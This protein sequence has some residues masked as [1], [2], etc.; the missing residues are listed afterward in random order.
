MTHALHSVCLYTYESVKY[1][2]FIHSLTYQ[3]LRTALILESHKLYQEKYSS[4]FRASSNP[5]TSL[6]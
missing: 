2:L 1:S 6:P 5:E 3:T 4:I